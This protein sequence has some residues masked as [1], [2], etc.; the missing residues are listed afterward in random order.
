MQAVLKLALCL[1]AFALA[2]AMPSQTLN[3]G[4]VA[5]FA[6]MVRQD[7]AAKSDLEIAMMIQDQ[8]SKSA[9]GSCSSQGYSSQCCGSVSFNIIWQHVDLNACV[10]GEYIP[11]DLAVRVKL[12]VLGDTIIDET[13][14]AHNP[15]AI[16]AAVPEVKV[17]SVCLKLSDLE[18]S[19]GF[20]GCFALEF[21]ALG[22]TVA[23]IDLGCI[24]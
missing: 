1:G 13:V 18:F 12:E 17:V 5:V 20:T 22:H 23:S 21:K 16:C 9:S 7:L 8:I 2:T 24:D 14:S 15:P 6:K 10:Y 19:N 11:D 3:S 4:D